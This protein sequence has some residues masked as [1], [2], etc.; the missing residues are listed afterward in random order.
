MPPEGRAPDTDGYDISEVRGDLRFSRRFI[1]ILSTFSLA[2]FSPRL[3]SRP[4]S[5]FLPR[6]SSCPLPPPPPPPALSLGGVSTSRF[7]RS[8]Y[9]TS[10]LPPRR[11]PTRPPRRK[12]R[13]RRKNEKFLFLSLSL[14]VP[15]RIILF[16]FRQSLCLFIPSCER[17]ESERETT[18][19][20]RH[21]RN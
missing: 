13:R 4:R 19:R 14:F 1:P 20:A 11:T 7:P 6:S 15:R 18:L 12:K 2:F 5:L 17:R 16:I 10:S 9:F 3:P 21:S 8:F